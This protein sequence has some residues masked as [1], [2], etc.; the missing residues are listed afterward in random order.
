MR[1]FTQEVKATATEH[2][3]LHSVTSSDAWYYYGNRTNPQYAFW[4][5]KRDTWSNRSDVAS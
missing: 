5:T 3:D 2:V 4:F 1:E